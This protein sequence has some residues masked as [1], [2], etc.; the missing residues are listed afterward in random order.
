[1]IASWSMADPIAAPEIDYF[2]L[3]P[4]LVVGGFAILGLL[5]EAVMSP[6]R[7]FAV[8]AIVTAVGLVAGLAVTVWVHLEA[9]VI[10]GTVVARGGIEGVGSVAVDGPALVTWGMLLLF[11]LLGVALFADRSFEDGLSAFTGRAA[12]APG[13]PGEAEATSARLEHTEVFPLL[14]FALSGMMLFAAS[15][16]LITMFV[17]L[18][19][20]SLPLYVLCGLARRRRVISQEAA[21]KYFMLGAFSS[22]FFLFG[23]ALAYGYSGSLD[24]TGIAEAVGGS[25]EDDVLML[26]AIAMLTVGLLFKVAGVPFHGW[27]PDVYQGAPTPVTAFMAA[28]TKAAAF[29]ALMRVLYVGFGGAAWDWRPII[30]V[31]AIASMFVG[32]VIA[33][34]Q[35]DVKRMLAYS[36][37]AHTGFLLVGVSGAYAGEGDVAVTSVSSVLLYLFVYGIGTIGAFAI[38]MVVRDSSGETTHLAKWAG[39]GKTSPALAGAFALLMISFAGIPL[40]A[41]FIAKW[42]VLSAAWAGGTGWLSIVGV[43]ISAIAAYFYVRVIVLMFFTDPVGDGPTVARTG[44]LTTVVVALSV[45]ATVV[46][47]VWPAPLLDLAQHAGAFVR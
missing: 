38:V 1:M 2:P 22:V 43:V 11:G 5:I 14:L 24:L 19:V 29:I 16:D 10:D 39:L 33:I 23:A 34:A 8:Q 31:I 45:V 32:A 15:H 30:W 37:V 44:V 6:R 46:F 12:D 35:T 18:E 7:R 40:T 25:A 28:A 47:G 26:A 27:T 17:A 9:P 36:A 4:L 21:L 3:L 42:G 41:G 13:S 20:L